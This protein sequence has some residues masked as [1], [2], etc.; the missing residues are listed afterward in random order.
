MTD[1]PSRIEIPTVSTMYQQL[2]K[3]KLQAGLISTDELW[4]SRVIGRK[5]SIYFTWFFLK[6]GISPNQITGLAFIM[7]CIGLSLMIFLKSWVFF[8][9]FICFQLYIILDSSDGEV[10]RFL[11]LK[12]DLGAF[13]DKLLH[14]IMKSGIFISLGIGL[15]ILSE[16]AFHLAIGLVTAYLSLLSSTF[17]HLLPV[18]TQIPYAQQIAQSSR[19]LALLRKIYRTITGDIEISL[20][21]AALIVMHQVFGIEILQALIWFITIQLGLLVLFFVQQMVALFTH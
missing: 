8:L 13:F 12:S 6:T 14:I 1:I 16:N 20:V 19:F 17:Y 3:N 5:I 11:S 10:A 4:Y 18:N 7:G 21:L 2:S 15:F 9:G